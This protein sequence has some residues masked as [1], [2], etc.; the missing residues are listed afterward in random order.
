MEVEPVTVWGVWPEL[1][2][3]MLADTLQAVQGAPRTSTGAGW[4][5]QRQYQFPRLTKI[6]PKILA[7]AS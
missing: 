2:I 7:V 1:R 6:L 3:Q 4:L 5:R